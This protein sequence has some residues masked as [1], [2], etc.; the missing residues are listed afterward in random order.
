MYTGPWSVIY[1]FDDVDDKLYVFHQIFDDILDSYAPIKEVKIRIR[2]NP[3]VTEEIRSLM[4]MRDYW[5][6]WQGKQRLIVKR[7][8]WLPMNLTNFLPQ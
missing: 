8:S 2:P 7:T 6:S 5:R 3:C 1:I 4:K